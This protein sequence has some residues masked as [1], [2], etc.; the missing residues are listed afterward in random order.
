MV[1]YVIARRLVNIVPFRNDNRRSNLILACK[2]GTAAGRNCSQTHLK[3][4]VAPRSDDQNGNVE[5]I[6]GD[7]T[8]KA[9]GLFLLEF[10]GIDQVHH[11]CL[12]VFDDGC[13]GV[14][15]YCGIKI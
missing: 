7:I 3:F 11:I 4:Q 1:E 2:I 8:L 9:A 6:T 14:I 5:L 13:Q 12:D 10:Q 15:F